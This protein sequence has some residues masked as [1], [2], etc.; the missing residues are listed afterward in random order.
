MGYDS[1]AKGVSGGDVRIDKK[2]ESQ[3]SIFSHS[4]KK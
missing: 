3:Y 1:G 2:D 4:A